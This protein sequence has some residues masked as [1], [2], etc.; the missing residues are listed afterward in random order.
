MSQM[1][2]ADA[3]RR[4]A[5]AASMKR[6]ANPIAINGHARQREAKNAAL[7]LYDGAKVRSATSN[8]RR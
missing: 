2:A 1:R 3:H 6:S 7:P 4:C 8:A 5:A